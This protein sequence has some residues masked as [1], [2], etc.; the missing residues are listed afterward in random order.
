MPSATTTYICGSCDNP[1]VKYGPNAHYHRC[2]K[3]DCR[4]YMKPWRMPASPVNVNTATGE[5]LG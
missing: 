1:M 5:V 4:Q 3:R 2:M